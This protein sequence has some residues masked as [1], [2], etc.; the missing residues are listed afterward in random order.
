VA[1]AG[2]GG[3][4]R[5]R[6]SVTGRSSTTEL[7]PATPTPSSAGSTIRAARHV[8]P[9]SRNPLYRAQERAIFTMLLAPSRLGVGRLATCAVGPWPP[10]SPRPRT[11]SRCSHSPSS[12]PAARRPAGRRR[13]VASDDPRTRSCRHTRPRHT[14]PETMSN[15]SNVICCRCRSIPHT[16][17]IKNRLGRVKGR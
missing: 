15:T 17:P 1:D 5:E 4:R 9:S 7:V 3:V 6:R 13:F 14:S 8:A 12:P 16:M 2:G 10:R 11:A